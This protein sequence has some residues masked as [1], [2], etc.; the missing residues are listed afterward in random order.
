M[1]E[2]ALTTYHSDPKVKAS[3]ADRLIA[4]LEARA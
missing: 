1:S 2:R 4:A 3:E